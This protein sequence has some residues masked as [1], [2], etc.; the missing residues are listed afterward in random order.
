MIQDQL[1]SEGLRGTPPHGRGA[2]SHADWIREPRLGFLRALRSRLVPRGVH[3]AA[4]LREWALL[5]G[6]PVLRALHDC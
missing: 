2:V 3:H 6:L 5:H 4:H 1:D